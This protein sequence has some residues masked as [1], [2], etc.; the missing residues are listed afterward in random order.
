MGQDIDALSAIEKRLPGTAFAVAESIN[1]VTSSYNNRSITY[2]GS[3]AN[4][5]IDSILRSKQDHIN[6]IYQ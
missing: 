2:N 1:D 4:L 3:L 5:D 6:D